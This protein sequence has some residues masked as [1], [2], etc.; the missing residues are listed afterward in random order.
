MLCFLTLEQVI[1]SNHSLTIYSIT[2]SKTKTLFSCPIEYEE[3]VENHTYIGGITVGLLYLWYQLASF[4]SYRLL[5]VIYIGFQKVIYKGCNS[6]MLC[7]CYDILDLQMLSPWSYCCCYHTK[8]IKLNVQVQK[9]VREY[10]FS[11]D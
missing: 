4:C 7:S 1:Y 9:R 11:I 2:F 8:W 3:G 5:F 10:C 6:F